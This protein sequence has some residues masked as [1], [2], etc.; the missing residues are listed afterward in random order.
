MKESVARGRE[1]H[2][3]DHTGITAV[4]VLTETRGRQSHGVFTG[5]RGI[6]EERDRL[7]V[8]RLEEAEHEQTPDQEGCA[9]EPG[10]DESQEVPGPLEQ[11]MSSHPLPERGATE[12]GDLLEQ[13]PLSLFEIHDSSRPKITKWTHSHVHSLL[14]AQIRPNE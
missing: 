7:P 14:E 5:D 12:T 6:D 4:R 1:E 11:R 13:L 3:R 10:P 2:I 8:P 9:E